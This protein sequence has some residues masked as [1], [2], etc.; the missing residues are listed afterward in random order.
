VPVAGTPLAEQAPVDPFEFVRIVATAR[1]VM[2]RS[3]V[4]LSAGRTAMSPETQAL[5][6]LAGANSIFLGEKLLTTPN[7]DDRRTWQLLERLGLHPLDPDDARAFHRSR[8]SSGARPDP[9]LPPPMRT[10][11]VTGSD[12]GIG[13]TRVVGRDRPPP[14]ASPACACSS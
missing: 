7:P 6:F 3:M 11:F 2:P 9:A 1:I 13:K 12:T 5:C 14:L 10:I 4:R 8:R